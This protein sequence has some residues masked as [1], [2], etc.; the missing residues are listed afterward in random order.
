MLI[1]IKVMET[2]EY[3]KVLVKKPEKHNFGVLKIFINV[4][5]S[6]LLSKCCSNMCLKNH[7]L[8]QSPADTKQPSTKVRLI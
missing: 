8:I 7:V 6:D 2:D 3:Y 5:R 4:T 1:L